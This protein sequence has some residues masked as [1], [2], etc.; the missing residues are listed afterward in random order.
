M[1]AQ[2][3]ESP[4][5]LYIGFATLTTTSMEASHQFPHKH[6]PM[7][8]TT[9]APSEAPPQ[10]V[11]VL[12][13]PTL[14]SRRLGR[15]GEQCALQ[16]R[17]PRCTSL[18]QVPVRLLVPARLSTASTVRASSHA[19]TKR[20]SAHVPVGP[21]AR[22]GARPTTASTAY[23]PSLPYRVRQSVQVP[24]FTLG[25][26]RGTGPTSGCRRAT[27]DAGAL[28]QTGCSLPCV[29]SAGPTTTRAIPLAGLPC[30]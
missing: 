13:D 8:V 4:I 7:E 1:A 11:K 12:T 28:P 9:G 24:G 5:P 22:A 27:P 23:V 19:G 18:R 10:R 14:P 16:L 21:L 25:A 6:G 2:A 15:P 3:G 26:I 17:V 20:T 29:T 30:A